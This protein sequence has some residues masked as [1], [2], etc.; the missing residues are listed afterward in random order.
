MDPMT[1]GLSR[2]RRWSITVLYVSFEQYSSNASYFQCENSFFVVILLMHVVSLSSAPVD[3]SNI[4]AR[5][6][7]T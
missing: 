1:V 4:H 5:D 6:P 3:M 2:N 7:E